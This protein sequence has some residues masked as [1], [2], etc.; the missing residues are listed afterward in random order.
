MAPA[1]LAV[2][3]AEVDERVGGRYRIGQSGPDGEAGGFEAEVLE[4][5]AYRKRMGWR[6]P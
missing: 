1:S 5:L 2:T 4:L 6:F 3:R